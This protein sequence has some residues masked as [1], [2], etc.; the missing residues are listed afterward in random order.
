MTDTH[1]KSSA[2][3]VRYLQVLQHFN[4]EL[5]DR[6]APRADAQRLSGLFLPGVPPNLHLARQRIMIVGC[7]TRQWNVLRE[8]ERFSTLDH[9]VEQAMQVHRGYFEKQLIKA[10]IKGRAFHNFTRAVAKRCGGDGLIYANLLCMAWDTGSPVRS[11]H[12]DVIRHYSRLLLEQQIDFFQPDIMIFANGSATAGIRRDFFPLG[13]DAAGKAIGTDYVKK[14]IPNSQLWEFTLDDRIRCFRIQHP[15]SR[16]PAS[17]Q[18]RQF[19]LQLLPPPSLVL[20]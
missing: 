12:I 14:G 19:L 13:R 6:H 20:A 2:L 17:T 8:G 10:D 7:E 15:S 18:A 9:Y 4:T 5:L 16:S 1:L 3:A 11:P